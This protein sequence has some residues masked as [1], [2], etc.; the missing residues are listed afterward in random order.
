MELTKREQKLYDLRKEGKTLEE[1]AEIMGVTLRNVKNLDIKIKSDL[2][3][4]HYCFKVYTNGFFEKL[5]H[6]ITEKGFDFAL[7]KA[8]QRASELLKRSVNENELS[9]YFTKDMDGN[10]VDFDC[11]RK[12]IC[13]ICGK[14]HVGYGHNPNPVTTDGECCD[15]CNVTIVIP[16]RIKECAK[17]NVFSAI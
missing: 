13:C 5:I 14:E 3:A 15:N 1:C 9:L 11:N 8:V 17:R 12:Y 7:S 4:L 10:N 2:Y 6:V 16:A